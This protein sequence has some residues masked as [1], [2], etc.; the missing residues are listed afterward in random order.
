M[1]NKELKPK[2]SGLATASLT[3]GIL[4]VILGIVGVGIILGILAVVFGAVS[5]KDNKGKAL[6]GI[7][8]GII[9][10][11][12]PIAVAIVVF[13]VAPASINVAQTNQR[14]IQRKND[15]AVLLSDVAF[16]MSEDRGQLPNWEYVNEMTYKLDVI[17]SAA[18]GEAGATP[19]TDKAVYAKGADC[20][21][22]Q[23]TR[24]Y[25]ISIMLEDGTEYCVSS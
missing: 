24:I 15:V 7:I 21:G 13:V 14:D 22:T 18:D 11:I 3:L 12:V 23:S 9:G 8:T 5:I 25:S 10:I 20:D 17:K 2:N 4:A 16:R 19:T 1:N 6:A